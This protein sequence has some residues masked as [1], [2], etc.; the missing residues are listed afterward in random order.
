MPGRTTA[1]ITAYLVAGL[2]LAQNEEDALRISTGQPGGTARSNGMANAFGALGA[3]PVSIS[4]NPAGLAL[5]RTSGLSLTSLLE[6]NNAATEHYGT[7]SAATQTRFAFNNVALILNTPSKEGSDWRSGTFGVVY[8]RKQS[9]HWSTIAGGNDVP[10]TILQGFADEAEGISYTT[11]ED[12]L[13]FSAGLAWS[14]FALDTIQGS[15]TS[16]EPFLFGPNNRQTHSIETNGATTQTSFFCSGNYMDK[17]YLGMSI[18]V[19]GHRFRRTSTHTENNLDL[20][21]DRMDRLTYKEDLT[22]SGN[23]FDVKVGALV[24]ITERLRAGASFHSPQWMQLNDAYAMELQTTFRTPDN[25]GDYS[26][27]AI[28]PDGTFAYRVVTPWR[29]TASAAYLAGA[30]GAISVDYEYADMRSMRFKP[31]NQLEDL[32]DFEIENAAIQDRFRAVHTIRVGTEWRS[33]NWYYRAGWSMVPD[34]HKKG[35]ALHGQALKTYAAGIGYRSEHVTVDL[36]M[37]YALQQSAFFQYAPYLVR[38]TT[39]ERASYRTFLTIALRP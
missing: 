16:Y 4:I 21:L 15:A 23:G 31:S 7:S 26:Y 13:P 12:D 37:N 39:E 33:G 24:R 1:T 22:T 28:S 8:D 5:Y 29:T 6:V 11:I 10:S 14:T 35:D 32:Y 36:G 18:G 34:A 9:H 3:D 20:G 2:V 25:N 30:N 27:K 19:A 17:L 38:A